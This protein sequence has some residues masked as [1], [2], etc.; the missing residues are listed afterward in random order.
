MSSLKFKYV[1]RDRIERLSF[2]NQMRTLLHIIHHPFHSIVI[3]TTHLTNISIYGNMTTTQYGS[4]PVCVYKS[5]INT[6][7]SI[8]ERDL[9]PFDSF[10]LRVY[11]RVNW[12]VPLPRDLVNLI[13]SFVLVPVVQVVPILRHE[14]EPKTFHICSSDV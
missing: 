10:P 9:I 13:S 6:E 5:A 8:L 1:W 4:K 3:T 12:K 2:P 7:L 11:Y 14:H